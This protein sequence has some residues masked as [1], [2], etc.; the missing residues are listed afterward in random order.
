VEKARGGRVST[1]APTVADARKSPLDRLLS[2]G[3]D[4]R[5][6]EG[7]TAALLAL[8]GFLLL[9]SYYAIRPL[10]SALLQPVVLELPG[11]AVL[12]GPEIGSYS[13][14][15]LAALFLFIVPLYGA[16]ASRFTRI[17][18]LNTVTSFFI[19]TVLGFFLITTSKAYPALAGITFF[20][21]IGVFN[22]MVIAQFWSFAND[23]Y[24]PEQ[25]KR[26]FAIVGFGGSVGAAFG[27]VIARSLVSQF[28]AFFMM[29]VA[30]AM[31]AVCMLLTNVVHHRDR[32]GRTATTPG[33]RPAEE[34]IGGRGDGFRLV[35]AQRYLLC[36]GLLT[37]ITNIV[38][39]G[40]NYIRDVVV[41][42][43]AE[44]E[45]AA[46]A[47]TLSAQDVVFNY[48]AGMDFWQNVL[49]M[50]MQFFLVSRLF[51]YLGIGG[52]L[53]FLPL[54]A[55]G[56]YSVFALMPVLAVIRVAKVTENATD[57]SVQNTVRRALF[58]PTSREV[59]YKALQAVETF[60]WRAG[61]MLSAVATFVIIQ[62]L[63]LSVRS[64][65]VFN[66]LIVLVWLGLAAYL[67]REYRR[68]TGESERIAA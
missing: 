28:G 14:A 4:V 46:G 62:L 52:S 39:T 50:T 1:E 53:F 31:L 57:Y 61:D 26:L 63:Q 32:R 37:L 10:R 11:G 19:L 17:R 55:L 67:A 60:F 15:I 42:A 23:L 3:A 30:A 65:A 2:L 49:A 5:A 18:L 22:L 7:G 64:Y 56:S 27:S 12:R 43:A 33:E 8:N 20:L 36:I 44:A 51:K 38:N 35:L 16:L 47:T 41:F 59:K 54:I 25:G 9:A 66:I 68:R 24:T 40:G 48:M 58:L 13:G 45:V 29:I 34:A 6:G 21:W